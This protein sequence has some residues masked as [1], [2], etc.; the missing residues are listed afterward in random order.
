MDATLRI[1]LGF[2]VAII[3]HELTHLLIIL[4]YKIP[5]KALVLTKWS[6]IGFL[7]ENEKY[8]NDKKILVLLHFLPLVWCSVVLINPTDPFLVMFPLV[9][10]SGGIGDFYYYAKIVSLPIEKRLEW[11]NK[12]DEKVLSSI[13]WKLDINK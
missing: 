7:V 8:I 2:T 13:I 5:F 6:A 9:N 1:L 3:L 11:A 10:L 4:Y 12:M